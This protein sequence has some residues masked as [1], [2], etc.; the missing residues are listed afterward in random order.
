MPVKI[1]NAKCLSV[2]RMSVRERI[3]V[4]VFS[5]W[6]EG[7]DWVDDAADHVNGRRGK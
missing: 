5:K 6:N 1:E 4:W 3:C 7:E 2:V